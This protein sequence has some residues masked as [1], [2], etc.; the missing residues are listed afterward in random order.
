MHLVF[1]ELHACILCNLY[2]KICTHLT[3]TRM[4]SHA[5]ES[6]LTTSLLQVVNELVQVGCQYL[7]STGLLRIVSTSCN[8]SANDKLQ[9]A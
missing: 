6:L 1:R 7:L 3:D 2:T 8:M 5:C 9:Q 4:R